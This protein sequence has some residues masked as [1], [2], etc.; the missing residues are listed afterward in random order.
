M[1]M[2]V[3]INIGIEMTFMALKSLITKPYSYRGEVLA[4]ECLENLSL[5]TVV[6]NE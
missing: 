6:R 2:T 5:Q 3:G 4:G 1:K